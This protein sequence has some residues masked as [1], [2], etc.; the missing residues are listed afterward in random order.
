ME[1]L[2]SWGASLKYFVA[3]G[4]SPSTDIGVIGCSES[5][6]FEN[7][8]LMEPHNATLPLDEEQSDSWP[9][10]LALDLCSEET[11]PPPTPDDDPIPP[12][13]ILWVYNNV[14]WLIGYHVVNLEAIS[15]KEPCSVMVK[16]SPLVVATESAKPQTFDASKNAVGSGFSFGQAKT[17]APSETKS[18]S[19]TGGFSFGSAAPSPFGVKSSETPKFGALSFGAADEKKVEPPKTPA[20]SFGGAETKSETPFGTR[21]QKEESK[22]TAKNLPFIAPKIAPSSE[23][24]SAP[25]I[26]KAKPAAPVKKPVNQEAKP[27]FDPDQALLVN[28][29]NAIYNDFESDMSTLKKTSNEV[30]LTYEEVA[31]PMDSKAEIH[32]WTVGNGPQIKDMSQQLIQDLLSIQELVLK[33]KKER[34]DVQSLLLGALAKKEESKKR[35]EILESNEL[36]GRENDPLGPEAQ[37]LKNT[38]EHKKN[39]S[40]CL[41]LNLKN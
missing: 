34:A 11:L 9:I 36:T 35:F 16:A 13:P 15:N 14:G 12:C 26:S 17:S 2:G 3:F 38:I 21:S 22:E 20:F 23:Q 1:L 30:S 29:F 24:K 40:L 18:K 37:E 32:T 39:V 8:T 6:N 25:S 10:G 41:C 7:W 28:K 31:E 27:E 33:V 19:E 5:G 4:N